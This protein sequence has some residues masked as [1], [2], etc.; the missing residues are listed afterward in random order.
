M[1]SLSKFLLLIFNAIF[2]VPTDCPPPE[3]QQVSVSVRL[4]RGCHV[5]IAHVSF[6]CILELI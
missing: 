3:A 5:Y 1:K 4:Y 2:P 6:Y